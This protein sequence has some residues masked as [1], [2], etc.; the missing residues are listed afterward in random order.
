VL[1]SSIPDATRRIVFD[2]AFRFAFMC[3]PPSLFFVGEFRNCDASPC[4]STLKGIYEFPE[5]L[6]YLLSSIA[7]RT[8]PCWGQAAGLVGSI[9]SVQPGNRHLRGKGTLKAIAM[10]LG[11]T[12]QLIRHA[13][14]PPSEVHP[15]CFRQSWGRRRSFHHVSRTTRRLPRSPSNA[16]VTLQCV[17]PD[18]SLKRAFLLR[19][20]TANLTPGCAHFLCRNE[21]EYDPHALS[22]E[23]Y[24]RALDEKERKSSQLRTVERSS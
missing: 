3:A 21:T 1:A 14:A 9:M 12:V 23:C 11:T 15:H 22:T 18:L 6:C 2:V 10:R 17:A 13:S 19:F 20:E 5:Y 24:G 16:F 4:R 8:L 7:N